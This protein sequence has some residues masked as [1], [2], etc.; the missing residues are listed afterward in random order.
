M[1]PW[2]CTDTGL[3]AAGWRHGW[4]T[5]DGPD[6]GGD[7]CAADR[8]A[9]VRG[10][11]ETMLA[12]A[13][14]LDSLA[15]ARQVHGGMVLEATAPGCLGEADAVWTSR[16]GLGVAGRSA[17]CPLVLVGIAGPTPV[18]GFAHASWRSTVRA[19]TAR[20]LAAMTAAGGDPARA[21]AVICPS[22]G[23]CCYEVG[24]E[25]H[26]EACRR[27]GAAAADHFAP[28]GDRWILDLWAAN[29]AQLTAAGVPPE[30]IA[31][32]GVCTIC[33]DR[34]PSHRRQGAAAGRFAAAI[35]RPARP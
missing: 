31:V 32:A 21:R 11:P 33:T 22:A 26:E 15:W 4:S 13:L 20:L 23:P 1:I 27:L 14:G 28:R 17:D 19:I 6:F 3:E 9:A 30:A 8:L 34:F 25:V 5:S 29:R 35:G 12:A 2:L 10:A 24:P 18:W 7:P 16:P